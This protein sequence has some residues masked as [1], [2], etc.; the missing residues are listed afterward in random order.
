[1][2]PKLYIF[3]EGADFRYEILFSGSSPKIPKSGIFGSKFRYFFSVKL[4]NHTKSRVLISNMTILFSNS[5]SVFFIPKSDIFGPK[6]GHFGL[7]NTQIWGCWFQIWQYCFQMP[8]QKYP[9]NAFLVPNLG[10]FVESVDLRYDNVVFKSQPKTTQMR[11]FWSKIVST[12]GLAAN[13]GVFVF[14]AKFF[15]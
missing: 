3:V 4:F 10:T 1:M 5:S 11:C 9:N 15:S 12:A 8:A 13:L 14:S 6:F 2:F 7:A